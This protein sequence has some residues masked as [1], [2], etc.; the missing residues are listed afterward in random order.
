MAREIL[1]VTGHEE[2]NV[3][4]RYSSKQALNGT[5]CVV[6]STPWPL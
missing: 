2:Q 1:L 5:E 6:I 4:K 3:K